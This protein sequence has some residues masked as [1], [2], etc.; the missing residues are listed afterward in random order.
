MQRAIYVSW[1]LLDEPVVWL[2]CKERTDRV[3]S[4]HLRGNPP[5]QSLYLVRVHNLRVHFEWKDR[6]GRYKQHRRAF[7]L[8]NGVEYVFLGN[9]LG[10]RRSEPECYDE[11]QKN[12]E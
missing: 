9:Q 12:Y 10:A 4:D 2:Q 8:Y 3:S 1:L 5:D 6:D 7:F 11:G